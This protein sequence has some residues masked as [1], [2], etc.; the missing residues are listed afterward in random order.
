[1]H[2]EVESWSLKENTMEF[3][4]NLCLVNLR[5]GRQRIL[6][7]KILFPRIKSAAPP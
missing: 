1:M 6:C 2:V 7:A 5:G 3:Y 4:I